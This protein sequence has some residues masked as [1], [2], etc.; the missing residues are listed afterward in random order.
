MKKIDLL[1]LKLG[2]IPSSE[3]D[4][5][6]FIQKLYLGLLKIVLILTSITYY[7]VKIVAQTQ[8]PAT[9]Q[10]PIQPSQNNTS[11]VKSNSRPVFVLPKT[12]LGLSPISGRRA[13]MGSRGSCPAVAS[14][15]TA[16]VPSQN[17]SGLTTFEHPT[18]WFY[19]PYTKELANL[20]A[21]FSLED[22]AG[23]DVYRQEMGLPPKPGVMGISLPNTVTSL[24]IGK[25]Y[26][27]YL[28]VR[29]Q[30]QTASVPV[31]VEGGIQR[32]NLD[33]QVMQQLQATA[34]SRQKIA[35][36][37]KE[38]IW[39]DALTLLA[40]IRFSHPHDASVEAD[41]ESLLQA[42][43]LDNIATAPSVNSPVSE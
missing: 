23:G 27:W 21:E 38:G 39:F 43:N 36:Y 7:P 16:L 42:V 22:S 10:K 5:V 31:Y 14:P 28:K 9:I 35:I 25:T 26:H 40:Q 15:L 2:Y 12:P 19:V 32:I 30:Q 20:S 1:L 13:G 18:F 41:W 11:S 3:K 6:N 8:Q 33:S 17:G 34:D 4:A 37:A 29:C 24:E